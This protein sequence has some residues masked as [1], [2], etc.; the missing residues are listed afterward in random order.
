VVLVVVR[1][2]PAAAAKVVV[3]ALGNAARMEALKEVIGT[4]AV[5]ELKA[6][7]GGLA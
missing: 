3:E 6:S 4:Y 1:C 2:L 7:L 5:A